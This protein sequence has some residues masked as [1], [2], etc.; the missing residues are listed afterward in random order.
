V[1]DQDPTRIVSKTPR[2]EVRGAGGLSFLQP[3][4]LL[5]HTYEIE[6]KLARGGMGEVYRARHVELGSLHAIKV[7]LPE[8]ANDAHIIEM[9][10]EEARKLRMVRDD[11][12]VGYEGMFRDENGLRYLVM[13]FVDGVPLAQAMR[14]GPLSPGA[15][16]VLR[17][18][19][20]QGLAA[21]HDKLIYHRDISP[22]N[23]ILVEGRVEQAKIIDFGIAKAAGGERTV[24]GA[25]FA[26]KF[27]YV[28]PEQLGLFGGAVDQRSDIYSLG[29]VLA[30][31]ALGHA[32]PMGD[33][34]A[35]AVE[36]RRSVPD[37]SALPADLR[38]ELAPLLEPNPADRPR[39]MRELPG[40]W[41]AS[42]RTQVSTPPKPRPQAP[43]RR[44]RAPL[45]AAALAF[46]VVLGGGAYLFWE[47]EPAPPGATVAQP[48][49]SPSE[50][51][52][53]GV[54]ATTVEAPPPAATPT[55]RPAAPAPSPAPPAP[56][57]EAAAPLPASPAPPAPAPAPLPEEHAA[58]LP[59]SP[60]PAPPQVAVVTP[61]PRPA[62]APERG[63]IEARVKS[64]L[65]GFRCADLEP[66]LSRDYDL[67]VSGFV[68]S[69]A[70]AARLKTALGGID[71]IKQV[72]ASV[73]VFVWPH[74]EVVKH[75]VA[76]GALHGG[77]PPQ[78]HVNKPDLTYRAGDKLVI[79]VTASRRFDGYLYVDYLDNAGTVVHMFP[80]NPRADNAVKAGQEVTLGAAGIYEI[81][82]PFGPNLIVAISS[83]RP[84]E[85][86]TA[87]MEDAKTY[88]PALAQALAAARAAGTPPQ[89]AFTVINTLAK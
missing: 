70:D 79:R 20:A 67:T 19:L 15:L 6:A 64:V 54:A 2:T 66:S 46:I 22:D 85:H 82:E 16:R 40:S 52:K 86:A 75:L 61:P 10:T 3:G 1:T 41:V 55:P 5:G 65:D 42:G 48:A 78:L 50:I 77:A 87:Q 69:A 76:A 73:A 31:A 71:A 43:P 57:T 88:L 72:A 80:A 13:E 89:A 28:S 38:E 49:P 47:R 63:A 27:S 9:F 83:P 59:P 18:R 58:A 74:C 35:A 8:L 34:P 68:S 39:S 24:V 30:A 23:I 36:A 14:E 12:V 21:A 25:D 60:P 44:S 37:L 81:S 56:P 4:Q 84:L 26:G 53:P 51:P 33:S 11:A 62:P 17:D 29:L 7:I 45:L 32:L